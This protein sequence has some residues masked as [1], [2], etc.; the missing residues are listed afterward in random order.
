MSTLDETAGSEDAQGQPS[1]SLPSASIRGRIALLEKG[2]WPHGRVPYGYDRLYVD[3]AGNERRVKR[4]ESGSKGHRCKRLL[5]KNDEEAKVVEWL[6]RE[7]LDKDVSLRQLSKDLSSRNIPRPDG[8]STAWTDDAVKQI[9]QNKAYAGYA[10]IDWTGGHQ[11]AAGAIHAIVTLDTW[12]RA[13]EKLG[14]N[15]QEGRKVQP[16]KASPLSGILFCGHC[17]NRLGKHSKTDSSGKHH[18]YFTCSSGAKRHDRRCGQWPVYEEEILPKVIERLVEEVDRA[19]LEANNAKEP[20]D[21]TPNEL[22]H[23]KAKLAALVRKLDQG[24]RDCLGAPPQRKAK[25]EAIL[26]QWEEEQAELER[27]IRN[28]TVTEDHVTK[29]T[30]WWENLKRELVT[31]IHPSIDV[32]V[33]DVTKQRLLFVTHPTE[34]TINNFAKLVGNTAERIAYFIYKTHKRWP[35]LPTF[36]DPGVRMESSRFRN[37]LRNLGFKVKVWWKPRSVTKRGKV[38]ESTRHELDYAEIEAGG[39]KNKVPLKSFPRRNLSKQEG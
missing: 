36:G 35:E 15:R 10:S 23:L 21:E 8:K 22:A 20:E 3:P 1:V 33:N 16:S 32:N 9:L 30:S 12:Q 13:V 37:L 14:I 18:T 39:K 29:F 7:Y 24:Y 5:V 2:E 34:E 26:N 4:N 28:L 11:E 31:V 25:F 38:Q 17:E 27:R 19:I 6:F